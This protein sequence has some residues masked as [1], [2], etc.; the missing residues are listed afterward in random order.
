[1]AYQTYLSGDGD[2]LSVLFH[3]LY[4]MPHWVGGYGNADPR[5]VDPAFG[6]PDDLKALVKRAHAWA[7]GCSSTW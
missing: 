1:M 6:T 2:R 4:L 5:Q 3:P 7:C